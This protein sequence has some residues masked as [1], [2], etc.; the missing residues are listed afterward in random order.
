MK[1]FK[2]IIILFILCLSFQS[3]HVASADVPYYTYTSDNEDQIIRTQTAYE[4]FRELSRFNDEALSMPEHVF[5]DQENYVYITDSE[6]DKVIILDENYQYYGELVSDEWSSIRSTFVSDEF[7]YVVDAGARNILLFDKETHVLVDVIGTP[8]AP[9]FNEGY[10]FQPTHIA[11]DVRGNIYVR[12]T[13]S[14]NGLIML[15]RD[16]E[17]ITFFGANPLDVPIL[18][19]I[20]SVFLTE[21]QRNRL[22]RSFPNIISDVAVD[23]KGFIYTVTSSIEDNSVKKF[24]VSGTNYFSDEVISDFNMNSIWVGQHENVYTVTSDG[25]IYEYDSQGQLLFLFGGTDSS[26]SRFGL[27]SRP[28]SIASNSSDDLIVVDQGVNTIQIYN[29]TSF[30]AAVHEAMETYQQGLYGESQDLWEYTLQYN[31]IFDNSHIGLGNAYVREGAFDAAYQEFLFANH[32]EGISEAFWELRQVWLSDNL[33]TIFSVLLVGLGLYILHR[34]LNKKYHYTE[35]LRNR[36]KP[37][38]ERRLID[39]LL[40]IFTYHRSPLDG[41]EEVQDSGRI[42][43]YTS[44]L[45]YLFYIVI[46]ILHHRFTNV[47]FVPKD[48]YILYELS[49]VVFLFIL[50]IVSNY[51]ICSINDG[52]GSFTHVYN[53]TAYAMTPIVLVMP[54]V[55]LISNGLTLEQSIFYYLPQALMLIWIVLLL[56]FT[57][58]DMHN[59][60]VGETFSI[61]FKS[62]FTMLIIGLFL[63]VL[64]SLG[65]QMVNFVLDVITEVGRR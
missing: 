40:F 53:G 59:Y 11:V 43:R 16:G 2:R 64:Y 55:I 29:K 8:E 60:E 49:I 14:S 65:S 62:I 18:D 37:V 32:S 24:N 58:K 27:M 38:T 48:Q 34:V 6:L 51:L 52:E 36:L 28:V 44:S 30:A 20:R 10:T 1:I 46:Y 31:S 17:F 15:N 63:F 21:T 22:D 61:V 19:Q 26:S 41:I 9:V 5:V 33:S 47:I 3:Q 50:W 45:L 4:P 57:I 56:F 12:S 25:W 35:K 23:E 39:N 54:F 13:E 7:I 42:K